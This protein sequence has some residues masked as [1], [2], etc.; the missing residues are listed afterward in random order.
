MAARYR[1]AKKDNYFFVEKKFLWWWLQELEYNG[2]HDTHFPVGYKDVKE[3]RE[4]IR[5]KTTKTV[6]VIVR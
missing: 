4:Y 6:T 3:A 2:E 1:I 5:K